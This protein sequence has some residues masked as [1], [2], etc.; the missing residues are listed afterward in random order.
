MG[1][2]TGPAAAA[3]SNIIQEIKAALEYASNVEG[4]IEGLKLNVKVADNK[5]TLEGA[6]L[7]YKELRDSFKPQIYFVDADLYYLGIKDMIDQDRAVFLC[8]AANDQR[9]YN[10]PDRMFCVSTPPSDAF[11]GYCRWV[12]QDWKGTEKPKIGV[13]YWDLASGPMYWKPAEAWVTKQ[14]VDLVPV[15]YPIQSLSYTTQLMHLRDAGVNYIWMSGMSQGAV[16]AIR[17]WNALGMNT[18]VP[19]TFSE[20]NESDVIV[21][22]AG[23]EAEGYYIIRAESPYSENSEG[24]QLYSKIIKWSQNKDK[25]S[26]NRLMINIKATITAAVKQAIQDVGKDKIDGE[27][28]YNALKKLTA[29]DT[30]GNSKDFGFGP[31]A[32]VG[33][34]T[35]KIAKFTQTGTVAASDWI[36]IPNIFTGG[37]K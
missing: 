5:G 10:P 4:G 29:I 17:D 28:M 24:A 36:S 20:G 25:W 6:V 23:K 8:P 37:E 9:W 30:W 14:G 34:H 21:N 27:A 26:D 11:A 12:L 1:G 19:I 31:N 35:I 13:L 32:R 15:Q 16:M 3:V 7:A 33:V 18:K 2:I 22:L